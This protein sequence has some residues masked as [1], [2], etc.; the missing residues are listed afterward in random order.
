MLTDYS[1]TTPTGGIITTFGVTI[2]GS[3]FGAGSQSAVTSPT[4]ALQPGAP[5]LF[6][7]QRLEQQLKGSK[8]EAAL[9]IKK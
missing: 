6:C 8:S 3:S 7:E 9:E 4:S 1:P 2:L 5:P